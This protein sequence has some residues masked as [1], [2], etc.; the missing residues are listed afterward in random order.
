MPTCL[1]PWLRPA[2]LATPCHEHR[3]APPRRARQLFRRALQ[4]AS[5]Q[6]IPGRR[7]ASP[8]KPAR[9]PTSGASCRAARLRRHPA[10]APASP[11][12]PLHLSC[13]AS[14]LPAAPWPCAPA[15]TFCRGSR[16]PQAV[17][18]R[19]PGPGPRSSSPVPGHAALLLGRCLTTTP[20]QA[21]P[22][23]PRQS[24]AADPRHPLVARLAPFRAP[25]LHRTTCSPRAV[26]LGAVPPSSSS[27]STLLGQLT[28]RTPALAIPDQQR[29]PRRRSP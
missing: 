15:G 10:R 28:A 19:C 25:A 9:L 24:S 27:S 1:R 8:P 3:P 20:Q 2:P 4:L 17:L 18:L 5:G 12:A 14:T 16:A 11:D 22:R 23:R 29:R 13:P 6:R 21:P 7:A 26:A